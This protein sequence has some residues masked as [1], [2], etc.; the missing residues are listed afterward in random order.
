[1]GTDLHDLLRSLRVW[2]VELPSF[3]P[4]AAPADPLALFTAWFAEAVAAGHDPLES[5]SRGGEEGQFG[6]GS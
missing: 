2:D 4:S 1:M 5:V 6:R 3:D